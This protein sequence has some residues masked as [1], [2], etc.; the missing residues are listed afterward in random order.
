LK[1]ESHL[2]ITSASFFVIDPSW[3]RAYIHDGMANYMIPCP[4]PEKV[5]IETRFLSFLE[6]IIIIQADP[7]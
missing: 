2:P 6:N 5:T 1:T 4:I 7:A 3:N